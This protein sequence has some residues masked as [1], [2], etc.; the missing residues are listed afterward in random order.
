MQVDAVIHRQSIVHSLVEFHDGAMLAQLGTPDM[1]LPIRYAMTYPNRAVSP[2]EPLDLLKCPP[3]TFAEPDEEVFRC[4]KIAKQC[5]AVGNVYCAAMNGANEE[6][7]AAFLR[8]EIGI[9]AIPDLIEAALDKTETGI[10][11]AAF[12]YSGSRPRARARSC[13]SAYIEHLIEE[14]M[15]YILIAILIFGVLIA[16]HEFGHFLAAKACGVRVNEFSIGMGPQL[17]HKTKGDTEYSLRLLPIGGYC[18]MEGEDEDSDDDRALG[19]Q[20][21]WKK[22]IIFVAGAFMN[23]LTG[24]IIVICLYAGAQAFY[25][26]EIVELNPD[27]PQQGEDGLMPGDT[28]YAINGERIYLKSDV[29]LI[30]GLGDTGT[31]DMTVLRDGKKL[32]R[33][34]TRQ[35]Y[36]DEN[37]KEY[38]AYGFTYGGI[39]EATPLLRLQYSWYQTMDYVRIVRLSLQ[40]LL[41]GAAGVNDLSG[42]VGIVS[43]ITEVGKETEAE[44][45][46]G[47]ALESILYFAAM[48]AV[49][50]AVM[51]LLPLPALDGGHVLFLLVNGIAV[52]LFKKEIPS[53]YLNVI[54]GIGFALLMALMLFVTFHDIVKL[55]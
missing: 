19:R 5:A 22:F 7:V 35:V 24:L 52:A 41:S 31:I 46:F 47:A 21:W 49:N 6:A 9:C 44:A 11:A 25:T 40:M 23:F 16:V 50:L 10:S 43:T 17:F 36:T 53:K 34:L 2:A 3:L 51:N 26:T 30:M 28:I 29:S 14:T 42:P 39:V 37:G 55:L 8:D 54:N 32:D 15:V 4:L 45:G 27:F 1:K 33:T 38:E 20:V 18:A 48:I 13:A 12:G